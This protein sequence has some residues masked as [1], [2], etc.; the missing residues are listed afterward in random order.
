MREECFFPTYCL[1]RG[2]A[3]LLRVEATSSSIPLPNWTARF[4][5]QAHER[6]LPMVFTWVLY[7]PVTYRCLFTAGMRVEIGA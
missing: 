4:L 6:I 3:G 5:G 7:I 1:R 2:I